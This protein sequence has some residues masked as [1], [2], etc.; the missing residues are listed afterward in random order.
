[1]SEEV[2]VISNPCS[3]IC[4]NEASEYDM[5]L[6][7]ETCARTDRLSV[8]GYAMVPRVSNVSWLGNSTIALFETSRGTSGGTSACRSRNEVQP[9]SAIR[10][11][12]GGKFAKRVC[13]TE[14][15]I[16][17]CLQIPPVASYAWPLSP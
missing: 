14:L 8:S 6:D 16:H 4:P 10:V 13:V 9:E 15:A 2:R 1:M 3:H 12:S 5:A 17:S 7:G 11:D